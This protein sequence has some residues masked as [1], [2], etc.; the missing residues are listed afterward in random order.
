MAAVLPALHEAARLDPPAA[1]PLAPS[2]V[3][4]LRQ[5]LDHRLPKTYDYHKVR[6]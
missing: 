1:R 2:L 3:S 5:V 4:I 6:T